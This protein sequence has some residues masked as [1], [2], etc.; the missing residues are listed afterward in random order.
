MYQW[1]CDLSYDIIENDWW[2]CAHKE[3]SKI[4]RIPFGTSRQTSNQKFKQQGAILF[5]LELI[6]LFYNDC[7][8]NL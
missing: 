7:M 1:T 2:H 6:E 3:N 4:T 5:V 8:L